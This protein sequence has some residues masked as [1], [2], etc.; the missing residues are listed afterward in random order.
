MGA[1]C[2]DFGLEYDLKLMASEKWDLGQGLD[3]KLSTSSLPSPTPPP[4]LSFDDTACSFAFFGF[5]V[6]L[7]LAGVIPWLSLEKSSDGAGAIA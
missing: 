2:L 1:G 4:Y 5:S 6:P 3:T 7:T